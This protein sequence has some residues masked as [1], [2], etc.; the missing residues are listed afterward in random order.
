MISIILLIYTTTTSYITHS[1][2]K[3]VIFLDERKEN[4]RPFYQTV[5]FLFWE[6]PEPLIPNPL[7]LYTNTYIYIHIYTHVN[8]YIYILI[9]INTRIYTYTHPHTLHFKRSVLHLF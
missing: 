4:I 7:L 8:M 6:T 9:H 3:D 1:L 2:C 5:P